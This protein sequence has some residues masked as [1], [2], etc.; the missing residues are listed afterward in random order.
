MFEF[1]ELSGEQR[2]QLTDARQVFEAWR[3]ARIDFERRF[4]GSM[5]WLTRRGRDYLH[6]K[7]GTKERSLGPR[8][9][10]TEGRFTGFQ[11]GREKA[12]AELKRLASRLDQMAPVNRAYGLGRI[13]KL[14]S[15]ILRRFDQAG[16]LGTHLIVIGTNALYCYEAQ[17]GVFLESGLLATGDADLLWDARQRMTL[18]L[19]EARRGGVLGLLQKTDRSFRTRHPGDYRAFN[20][21]GYWVDLIRPQDSHFFSPGSRNTVGD[22]P[23]DLHGAPVEG[24]RWLVSSPRT[25]TVAVGEDGYPVRLVVPDPRAF[26]LHKLWVSERSNRDP[27]KRP[28]D[29]AQAHSVARLCRAYLGLPFD[30]DDLKALPASLRAMSSGLAGND[31][32]AST[33]S[34]DGDIDPGC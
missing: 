14:T 21:D 9:P 31:D 17:A 34:D 23:G 13:P 15:R 25:T 22:A 20:A 4:T 28:R 7:R 2:R 11:E 32:G 33:E 27:A 3:Q 12:R 26:A 18:L 5:R 16:L 30:G 10:E 19:P 8:T 6:R 24:L 29:V 1:N